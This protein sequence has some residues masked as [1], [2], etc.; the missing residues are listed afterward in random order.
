MAIRYSQARGQ[1]D[2]RPRRERHARSSVS[3]S[4]SSASAPRAQQPN[5]VAVQFGAMI[6]EGA[7]KAFR[8]GHGVDG[9]PRTAQKGK[10]DLASRSCAIRITDIGA[11][12]AILES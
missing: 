9:A 8:V 3:C 4:A 6:L 2:A 10:A 11:P 12:R 1:S 7:R 5:A